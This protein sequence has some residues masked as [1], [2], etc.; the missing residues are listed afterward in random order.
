MEDS[1]DQLIL[2]LPKVKSS[3]LN[4]TKEKEISLRIRETHGIEGKDKGLVTNYSLEIWSMSH[5]S[6][7]TFNC[8]NLIPKALK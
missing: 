4:Q 3:I 5:F 7:Y 2:L 1:T 8:I 6:L